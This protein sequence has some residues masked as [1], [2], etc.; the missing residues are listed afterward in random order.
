M[1]LLTYGN[2]DFLTYNTHCEITHCGDYLDVVIHQPKVVHLNPSGSMSI[3]IEGD[4]TFQ[5]TPNQ[6]ITTGASTSI[7]SGLS[8]YYQAYKKVRFFFDREAL[9]AYGFSEIPQSITESNVTFEEYNADILDET[10]QERID[11]DGLYYRRIGIDSALAYCNNDENV[12]QNIAILAGQNNI[13]IKDGYFDAT[14]YTAVGVSNRRYDIMYFQYPIFREIADTIGIMET[15]SLQGSWYHFEDHHRG[16]NFKDVVEKYFGKTTDKLLSTVWN[17]LLVEWKN[18][19][20]TLIPPTTTYSCSLFIQAFVSGPQI[21]RHLGWDYLYHFLENP[22]KCYSHDHGRPDDD[23]IVERLL[24]HFS[25]RKIV[26]ILSH[27][28]MG[29]INDLAHMVNEFQNKTMPEEVTEFFPNGLEIPKNWK[30]TKELHDKIAKSHR[31]IKALMQKVNFKYHPLTLALDG[32]TCKNYK[33]IIPKSSLELVE[34]GEK[35]HNCIASYQDR[36]TRGETIVAGVEVDGEIKYALQFE[37]IS[38]WSS[39]GMVCVP[40]FQKNVDEKLLLQAKY[41]DIR[42]GNLIPTIKGMYVQFRKDRN[43]DVPQDEREPVDTIISEWYFENEEQ[44]SKI[45]DS[46]KND[47]NITVGYMNN[48]YLIPN[49]A[50]NHINVQLNVQ[51]GQLIANNHP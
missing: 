36:V 14:H 40:C 7:V 41:E 30:D 29:T 13:Y 25:P 50:I 39:D 18:V 6:Y 44:L 19:N 9:C 10:N 22:N 15:M 4:Q 5:F 23:K 24:N 21:L 51:G 20:E 45:Y 2:S 32:K 35:L 42:N 26:K 33:L 38:D 3:D 1:S 31:K 17:N 46:K 11:Y 28:D 27:N 34:W 47:H 49:P 8:S 43:I 48:N 37:Y 16:L 12:I